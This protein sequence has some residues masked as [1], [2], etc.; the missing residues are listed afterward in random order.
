M[1]KL[2]LVKI[3]GKVSFVQTLLKKIATVIPP[4]WRGLIPLEKAEN[5]IGFRNEG[6]GGNSLDISFILFLI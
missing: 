5:N 2:F 6:S 3:K 1:L 4:D